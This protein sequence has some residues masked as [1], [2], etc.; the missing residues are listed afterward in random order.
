MHTEN[1]VTSRPDFIPAKLIERCCSKIALGEDFCFAIS[2]AHW[3]LMNTDYSLVHSHRLD[4]P[5]WHQHCRDE[6]R[7]R[8][9]R[10]GWVP[11]RG[12]KQLA[13]FT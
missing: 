9:P 8:C 10:F 6:Q 12:R 7:P 1:P 3:P 11:E 4:G 5:F 13:L 2:D